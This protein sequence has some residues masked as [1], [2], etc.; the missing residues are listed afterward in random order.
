MLMY[1]YLLYTFSLLHVLV[2]IQYVVSALSLIQILILI[3]FRY[4]NSQWFML[5]T[6]IIS[7]FSI[8]VYPSYLHPYQ[9]LPNHWWL[10]DRN[11]IIINGI[12]CSVS[13]EPLPVIVFLRVIDSF[14]DTCQVKLSNLR[15]LQNARESCSENLGNSRW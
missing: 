15:S 8:I 7:W 4:Y 10:R 13:Y 11:W 1:D 6:I 5:I 9:I 12:R 2:V 14:N 3:L